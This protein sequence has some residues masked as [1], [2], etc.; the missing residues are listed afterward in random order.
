MSAMQELDMNHVLNLYQTS[1]Q[2]GKWRFYL[3][4]G[5]PHGPS[6]TVDALFWGVSGT[7]N[8]TI[9]K[10]WWNPRHDLPW[11]SLTPTSLL[12]FS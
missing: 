12:P 7:P 1:W 6:T 9:A 10:W 3:P 11:L 4:P 2:N 8:M 5:Y